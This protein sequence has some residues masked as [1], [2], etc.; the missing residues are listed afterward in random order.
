MSWR[1]IAQRAL[2]NEWLHWDVPLRNPQ[3]T[4]TLSG[5]HQLTASISPEQATV[6]GEDGLPLFREWSTI[7]YAE[8]DGII[9]FGGILVSSTFGEAGE[10]SLDFA[11]FS[12]Y[13][14]GI[15]YLG[16]YVKTTV[17]PLDAV[18]E[19]W[20][21]LQEQPDGYLGVAVDN[22]TSPVL[23]GKP[24]KKAKKGS[25]EENEEAEPY[26]LVWWEAKDCGDEIDQLAGQTPFDYY[27]EHAW[28]GDTDEVSHRIRLGYPRL[29]RRRDDLRFVLG[30]N[31]AVVPNV[32]RNG[33]EFANEVYGIGKGEGEKAPTVSVPQRDGRLRRVFV[34]TQSDTADKDRLTTIARTELAIRQPIEE[35]SEVRIIDHPNARLG[36]FEVGDDILV[37]G[38][39]PWLSDFA[40]WC[41][42]TSYTVQPEGGEGLATLTLARSDSFAY[43]KGASDAGV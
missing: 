32:E 43:G 23:V 26:E 40:I 1:Y 21:Y 36:S 8:A 22:T 28:V 37:Q 39:L 15:P 34:F 9:R 7:I 12:A 11:G 24:A 10:W 42:I 5:P 31:L 20:R 33:D 4:Y 18:R 13:P 38:D 19:I 25:S 2:T 27:E 16:E 29:G 6:T 14:K 30:E 17:D 41:R 3:L 35:L